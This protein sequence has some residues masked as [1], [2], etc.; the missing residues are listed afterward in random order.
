MS[1]IT[2]C[3]SAPRS[4]LRRR[5][6]YVFSSCSVT[7]EVL[8][9][10]LSLNEGTRQVDRN[11]GFYSY[12]VSLFACYTISTTFILTCKWK[13]LNSLRSANRSCQVKC[14]ISCRTLPYNFA[15][16]KT[17]LLFCIHKE[18]LFFSSEYAINFALMKI[19]L[20]F[21]I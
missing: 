2:S 9:A 13:E 14:M 10:R 6:L 11:N 21:N 1:P 5:V 19:R 3:Q 16:I 15:F 7:P 17:R 12:G 20:L 4:E 8:C 18:Y